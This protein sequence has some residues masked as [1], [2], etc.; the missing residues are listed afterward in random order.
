MILNKNKFFNRKTV[1]TC[2]AKRPT[3]SPAEHMDCITFNFI[4]LVNSFLTFF[5][6]S[7]WKSS[8]NLSILSLITP[9]CASG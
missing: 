9:K 3:G 7:G 2:A 8:S 4:A 6:L 1:L 5:F